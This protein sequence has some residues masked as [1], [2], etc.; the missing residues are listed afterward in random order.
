[1]KYRK[2][3]FSVTG[4]IVALVWLMLFAYSFQPIIDF[5]TDK[6]YDIGE[7]AD[8]A[9]SAQFILGIT[10]PTWLF[11][12]S[13]NAIPIAITELKGRLEPKKA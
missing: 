3:V 10:M 12:K 13:W 1:M 4:C 5:W 9:A 8:V 7:I 2:L 11:V 6:S